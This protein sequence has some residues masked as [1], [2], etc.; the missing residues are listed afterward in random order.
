MKKGKL[1]VISGPSGAGK[2]TICKELLK[3]NKNIVLSISMTTRQARPGEREGESYYFVSRE[4][5]LELKNKGGLLEDAEVF[6]NYYGTPK[7]EVLNALSLGRDVILEIDVQGGLQVKE[8]FSSAILIFIYPPSLKELENRIRN[9]GSETEA[10]IAKRLSGSRWELSNSDKYD[11]GLIND[12]LTEAV[13]EC[14]A[15]MTAEHLK[16]H[17]WEQ[18]DEE[19]SR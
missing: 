14:M 3:I 2:G 19:V 4:A 18:H 17:K 1:F 16:D 6:G 13:K 11:Y 15:I 10:E 9:R 5:F 8:N 7:E 12:D